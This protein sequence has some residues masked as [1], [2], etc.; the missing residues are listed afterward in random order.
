MVDFCEAEVYN[1]VTKLRKKEFKMNDKE[2]WKAYPPIEW[3]QGSNSGNVR[4]LDRCVTRKNGR[5]QFIKGRVLKQRRMDNGYMYVSFSVNGKQVHL[6]VHRI[7]AACFL[8]NPD[9]LPQVNHIDCDRTNNRVENLEWCTR[10]Y[11]NNYRDKFGY[12]ANCGLGRIP[13]I[14]INLTTLEVLR[15]PSQRGAA[16]QLGANL[17]NIGSVIKGCR[18]QTGGFWFTYANENAVENTRAKLGN[19]VA[20]KVEA[21]LKENQK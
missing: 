9:N 21:L 19:E 13:V 12:G 1:E 8:D 17:G 14:A 16:R 3:L 4:T 10:E 2:I 6:R 5:K 18:K 11:N 20:R 15:F 7:I